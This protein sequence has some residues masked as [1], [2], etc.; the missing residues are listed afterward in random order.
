MVTTE[1]ILL[2]E[3]DSNDLVLLDVAFEKAGMEEQ[4]RVVRDGKEVQDYLQ[5]AGRFQD[6][7]T[8]PLPSLVLLDLRLPRVNGL[9]VLRWIREQTSFQGLPVVILTGSREERQQIKAYALGASKCLPKP[10]MFK[11]LVDLVSGQL[12]NILTSLRKHPCPEAN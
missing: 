6:R 5:G 11:D 9:E 7:E 3:D 4:L 12:R 1:T 8:Y 10:L 2:A